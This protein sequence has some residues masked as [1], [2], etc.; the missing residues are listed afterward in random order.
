MNK[1]QDKPVSPDAVAD[2]VPWL[3]LVMPKWTWNWPHQELIYDKL[4]AVT[5]GTS[6]RLMI[7][8]P[9]RH[10]KSETVTVHYTAWRLI[11]EPQMNVILASYNQRLA[12]R[13]SR[14]IRRAASTGTALS[15]ERN[16]VDEWETAAGGTLCAV[17]T[18]GGA[19]GFG[20][21]LVVIDDPIK[22]RSEAESEVFRENLWDWFN[23]DIY[24]RL[25][26]NAAIIIIQTRWHEDDLAGRLIKCIPD[27]GEKWDVLSLPALAE[28]SADA[29]LSDPLGR[30]DGQALCPERYTREDLLRIQKKLGSYAFSALYQQSPVPRDG[31]IFKRRWFTRIIDKAPE[32]LRWCRAYDLAVSTKT[33]ADFT[34]SFRCARDSNN[35]FYI[36][37]G[38]RDRIEFPDQRRYVVDRMLTETNT[39]HVIEDALHGKA[40]VQDLRT[41]KKLSGVPLRSA[42]VDSDKVT[43]ALSW[44]SLAEAGMVILVHGGW[45]DDFLD[46]VDKFP[47][48][49]HDDQIDAVSLA[50]K[51]LAATSANKAKGF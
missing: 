9:P 29:P 10:S 16:A 4:R 12:N 7:F 45:I 47:G 1:E 18:G 19:T 33:S 42:R 38:F 5:E 13:F 39:I 11:R 46:E 30:A 51:M 27:G 15:K 3:S 20:A 28:V 34:A 26:P 43:R 35:N 41:E 22:S 24:T 37:D 32:G 2:F 31:G 17:G 49:K 6:K 14:K 44:A 48:G 40:F 50:I 21:Q 8:M 36:A 23:D 25:E